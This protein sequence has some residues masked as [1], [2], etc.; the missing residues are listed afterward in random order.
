MIPA[1][2]ANM[3][4]DVARVLGE[5]MAFNKFA[6]DAK[7]TGENLARY[8]ARISQD[9]KDVFAAFTEAVSAGK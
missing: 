7:L 1:D 4:P 3:R 8:Q 6:I 5:A 9:H 2:L